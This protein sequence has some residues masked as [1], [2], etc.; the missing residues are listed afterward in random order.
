M[1]VLYLTFYSYS[2]S[3]WCSSWK[4]SQTVSARSLTHDM[5]PPKRRN[6][7]KIKNISSVE[8]YV[9]GLKLYNVLEKGKEIEKGTIKSPK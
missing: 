6:F 3:D 8:K 1:S 2:E 9:P 7:I 5:L 4:S